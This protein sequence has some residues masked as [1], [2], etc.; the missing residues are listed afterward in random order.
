MLYNK[1]W[2]VAHDNT[3]AVLN[4]LCIHINAY[5]INILNTTDL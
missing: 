4:E 5:L 2:N 1:Q 3:T